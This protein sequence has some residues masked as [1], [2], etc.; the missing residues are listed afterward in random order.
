MRYKDTP[1]YSYLLALAVGLFGLPIVYLSTNY[2]SHSWGMTMMC[3]AVLN[4]LPGAAFGL[5]WPDIRWRWG[6]WLSAAPLC[7]LSFLQPGAAFYAGWALVSLLPSCA[8][9]R[10]VARYALKST[11]VI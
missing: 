1:P 4:A 10:A 8:C 6:V 11:K 2:A 9:A 7:V 3:F 5:V